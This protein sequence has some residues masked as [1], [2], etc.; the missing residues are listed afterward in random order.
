MSYPHFNPMLGQE[1]TV[2]HL[3][4]PTKRAADSDDYVDMEAQYARMLEEN[5]NLQKEINELKSRPF[6]S[7]QIIEK[8][9]EQMRIIEEEVNSYG[10][11][12]NRSPYNYSSTRQI[13]A[14]TEM[15][16]LSVAIAKKVCDVE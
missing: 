2:I 16:R 1:P 4:G 12:K 6:P 5:E 8:F 9:R 7:Q 3:G 14:S 15:A 11:D 13:Y 10:K